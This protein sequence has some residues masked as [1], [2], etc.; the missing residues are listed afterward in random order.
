MR[1]DM[2]F[3]VCISYYEYQS[4]D[5]FICKKLAD[6]DFFIKDQLNQNNDRNIKS[7]VIDVVDFYEPS[8]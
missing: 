1:D 7:I 2:V 3:A 5:N 8:K 6:I 4:D